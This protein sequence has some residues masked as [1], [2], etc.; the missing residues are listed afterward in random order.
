MHAGV[1]IRRLAVLLAVVGTLSTGGAALAADDWQ[2]NAGDDWQRLLAA[3]R[4]EGKVVVAGHPA[5][6]TSFAKEFERDTGIAL[7]YLSG[8]PSELYQRLTRE[9][10]AGHLTL[11]VSIGG[12]AELTMLATGQLEPIKPKLILPGVTGGKNWIGGSIKWM[13][14]QG[15]YF[16][17][18]SNWVFAWPTFNSDMIK[19]G[20][21]KTWQDL[22]KPAYKGKIAAYD[23]RI[24]GPGQGAASYVA[25]LFGTGFV[26]QLYIGQEAAT[27]RD[28]R[29]LVEWAA[30][31]LYPVVLGAVQVDIERYKSEGMKNLAVVQLEDGPGS[32]VGGFSVAKMPKGAPHPNAAAVFL[33]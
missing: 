21:V 29:Q 13:D 6:A 28:G 18:G 16:F 11:D 15:Q 3:A 33:N 7:E 25:E 12:G 8:G 10:G 14:K 9:A 17:Q 2:A 19:P 22:L 24:G 26:K 27:T 23:A 32:L 20:D 1:S 30:R 4:Q 5:L 31:G